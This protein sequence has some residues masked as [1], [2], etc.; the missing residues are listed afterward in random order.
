MSLMKIF[1]N[2]S[3]K[4]CGNIDKSFILISVCSEVYYIFSGANVF[5][6][7]PESA[8][9]SSILRCLLVMVSGTR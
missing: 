5:Q 3:F 8:I 9:C 1:R 2:F 6:V 7:F 4:N